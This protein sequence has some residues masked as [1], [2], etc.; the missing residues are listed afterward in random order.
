MISRLSTRIMS[1]V[2]AFLAWWGGELLLLTPELMRRWLVRPQDQLHIVVEADALRIMNGQS[3]GQEGFRFG[4]GS[5]LPKA[6]R[7]ATLKGK[8][9]VLYLPAAQVLRR[10]V[11]LP[12]AAASHLQEAASFQVGRV[13]PFQP[14]QVCHTTRLV[15]RDRERQVVR[16]ELAVVAHA[17]L[18][19][20]LAAIE[21]QGISLSAIR[22]VGDSTK[23]AL[24]FLPHQARQFFA[25]RGVGSIR[26]A[27]MSA[28]VLLLMLF[29]FVFAYSIHAR[30]ERLASE[31]AAAASH[32]RHATDLRATFD[33]RAASAMYLPDRQ[34]GLRAIEVLDALTRA[35]P[36]SSW[37]FRV[38][39]RANK[40]LLSGFSSDV[41]ELLG[42]LAAPPFRDPELTSQVVNA[43]TVGGRAG[44][45]RF[46]LGVRLEGAQP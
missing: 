35:I 42:R 23:P 16:V 37:L 44:Q 21:S 36:D 38:E 20:A 15:A 5:E 3:D 24:D 29:P 28:G 14:E 25:R 27:V 26:A 30:A 41:P 32:A 9:A 31:L 12:M 19:P 22:V 6:A 1:V 40:L 2:T 45:S 17:V 39:L 11:E 8:R 7:A 46:E 18:K 13:T 43:Q 34:R 4:L 10:I 33:A